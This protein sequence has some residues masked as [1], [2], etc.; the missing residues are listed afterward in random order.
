MA[1]YFKQQPMFYNVYIV[2]TL[3]N[4]VIISMLQ[5]EI[6]KIYNQKLNYF[7][8]SNR[9]IETYSH[10]VRSRNILVNLMTYVIV[11]G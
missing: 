3:D 1:F 6:L 9:T 8:Y 11:R 4:Y 7:N 10:Y 5:D 2:K